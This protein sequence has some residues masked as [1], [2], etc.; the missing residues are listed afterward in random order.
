MLVRFH[1]TATDAVTM[2][3]DVA[4]QLLKMM[5]ATGKVPGALSPDDV[6]D[7]LKRLEAR[8]EEVRALTHAETPA[9]PAYNEDSSPQDDDDDDNKDDSRSV[10]LATRAVPLISLLKRAAAANAEVVWEAA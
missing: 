5:G 9:P 4:T 6:P 2:F 3:G 10:S 1:S 8:V 7:A